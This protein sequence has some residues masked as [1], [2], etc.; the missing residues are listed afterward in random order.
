M[1][2]FKPWNGIVRVMEDIRYSGLS[3]WTMPLHST[4]PNSKTRQ[5][6]YA[7]ST[8]DVTHERWVTS[9]PE[10]DL[11]YMTSRSSGYQL[12]NWNVIIFH[13]LMFGVLY[14][15]KNPSTPT[16][17]LRHMIKGHRLTASYISCCT[18]PARILRF[19]FICFNRLSQLYLHM[20]TRLSTNLT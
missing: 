10:D 19:G 20:D 6:L 16:S 14:N 7:C 18:W 13:W 4:F 3:C 9:W 17:R 5:S 8:T 11:G 15:F 2:P 12:L 1:I